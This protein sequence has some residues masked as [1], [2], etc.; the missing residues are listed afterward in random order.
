MPR[1]RETKGDERD[2]R[3]ETQILKSTLSFAQQASGGFFCVPAT[4]EPGILHH[5]RRKPMGD[6]GLRLQR[7]ADCCNHVRPCDL[8]TARGDPSSLET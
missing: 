7:R 3:I 2:G 1:G 4:Q 6:N 8:G 5:F